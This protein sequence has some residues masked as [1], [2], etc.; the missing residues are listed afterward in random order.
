[1][2][3]RVCDRCGQPIDEGAL[4]YE[5]KVQVY[6]AY[7]PLEITFEDLAKDYTKEID[8]LVEECKD[9]SEEKLMKDVYI[10]FRE[11][12][13]LQTVLIGNQNVIT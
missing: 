6:A 2:I 10:G 7:D 5:A 4:R 12:P 11:L 8:R 9:L 1:M 13:I 3:T